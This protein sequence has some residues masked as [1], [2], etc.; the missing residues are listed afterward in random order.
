MTWI[1]TELEHEGI[2]LIMKEKNNKAEIEKPQ[3][4]SHL[5]AAKANTVLDTLNNLSGNLI[6]KDF[7]GF[8][9]ILPNTVCDL[10]SVPVC[11][12]WKFDEEYNK[13]RIIS[14][15]DRVDEAYRKIEL[16]F[17]DNFRSLL[18]AQNKVLALSD[19]NHC[20]PALA[21]SKELSERNWIS[22]LT[23]PLRINDQ[24]IGIL[25]VHTYEP[26]SFANWQK[27]VL[28]R[29]ANYTLL[30]L[31][32]NEIS[33]DRD[34]L[35]TLSNTMLK[36]TEATEADQL[37]DL[38]RKGTLKLVGSTK[39]VWVAKLDYHTGELIEIMP[40][41]TNNPESRIFL[42]EG[43]TGKALEREE[44]IN[45]GDILISDL[46]K[47]YI[48]IEKNSRSELAVPILIESIPIREKKQVKNGS[49]VIGILNIESPNT[50]AFSDTDQERLW[51]LCR[52]AALRFERLEQD[53]KLHALRKFEEELTEKRRGKPK[54]YEDIIEVVIKGI[55]E[56]LGFEWVNIS[57]VDKER[58]QI[59]S[60]FVVRAG[61]DEQK[62]A[63]FKRKT[64]HDLSSNDIQADI[65]RNP[66]I[67]VPE[68]DDYRFDKDIFEEFDHID[69]LR[70][71]I[72]MISPLNNS[73]IGTVEVGYNRKFRKFIF[74]QDVQVLKSFVDS[75]VHA[76]ERKKSG[77]IDTISHELKSPIIGIR[78]NASYIQR[79]I[80]A[81]T[82]DKI[83]I[84]CEDIL[85]DCDSLL[86]QV[87]Q[88]E[89]FMGKSVFQKPKIEK[90]YVFRDIIIKTVNQ[91]KSLAI[92]DYGL[93]IEN[94][95]Y[96]Q[97]SVKKIYIY[98]DKVKLSQVVY[99][100]LI[101]SLRY[102]EKDGTKFRIKIETSEDRESFIIK[103]KDWGMGIKPEDKDKIFVEG[104]RSQEAKIKDVT[105]SGLGLAISKGIMKHLGG[106][107]LLN[108]LSKPTEFYVVL[109]KMWGI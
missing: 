62:V 86:Y 41:I 16:A 105:G 53:S 3:I 37:W 18:F 91:L 84:K 78:A 94:I 5:S 75:A 11:I 24:V 49:K 101:N 27:K 23:A 8:I 56:T 21:D 63:D 65:V 104:F 46:K 61:W 26:T 89:H 70:V 55:T 66:E 74:E 54:T 92:R 7:Q 51:L 85:V 4:A 58:S 67:E 48:A 80:N 60:E 73:V 47:Y 20:E 38:L 14:S 68:R 15:S 28:K 103:F 90:I 32:K 39:H 100:L 52:Y 33:S 17:D 35:Q 45:I 64:I 42:G 1:L 96:D 93:P 22:L 76:L 25:N 88:I 108:R 102:A 12:L 31:Q 82:T 43:I 99:N 81:I 34:K 87:R 98:T 97:D 71:Y 9:E 6:S 29:L 59:K 36:M 30:S 69:L 106:D 109:P 77:I 72:P 107:L 40:K 50:S 13:F 2:K 79:R 19:V 10:L 83:R 95:E 57:L 44:P